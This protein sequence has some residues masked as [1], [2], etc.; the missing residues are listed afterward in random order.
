MPLGVP[1][2]HHAEVVDP[3]WHELMRGKCRGFLIAVADRLP[4]DT[5]GLAEELI[6]ANEYGVAIEIVA[7][8]LE[9]G[10]ATLTSEESHWLARLLS[11]MG[12][13]ER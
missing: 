2:L 9:Q 5:T 13:P 6:H 12:L 7:E 3:A 11:D 10:G 8:A 4:H 1:V